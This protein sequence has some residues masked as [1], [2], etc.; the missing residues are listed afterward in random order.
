MTAKLSPF[1]RL[2]RDYE[3]HPRKTVDDDL[4]M[5]VGMHDW[6]VG[7][8]DQDARRISGNRAHATVHEL[9]AGTEQLEPRPRVRGRRKD[10]AT[11]PPPSPESRQA[12][13]AKAKTKGPATEKERIF[14]LQEEGAC[15]IGLPQTAKGPDT[16]GRAA[17]G[18][19]DCS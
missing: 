2:V 12:S 4:K 3:V 7:Q 9:T 13:E 8:L 11:P 10:K 19:C 18:C 17:S 5:G 14:L 16:G 1:E 6:T 15:E